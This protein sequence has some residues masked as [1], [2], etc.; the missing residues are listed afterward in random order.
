[1]SQMTENPMGYRE[2]VLLTITDEI[3]LAAAHSVMEREGRDW[4]RSSEIYLDILSNYKD[5]TS[6]RERRNIKNRDRIHLILRRNGFTREYDQITVNQDPKYAYSKD[7]PSEALSSETQI[8]AE[9]TQTTNEGMQQ[10]IAPWERITANSKFQMCRHTLTDE[11][12]ANRFIDECI[13][14]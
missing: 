7:E 12:D 11:G 3:I 6:R 2:Y 10:Q 14:W 4:V 9:D 13:G 1:M 5:R 8:T